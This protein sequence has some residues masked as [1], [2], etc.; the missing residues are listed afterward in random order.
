MYPGESSTFFSRNKLNF[1]I[2][3][4]HIKYKST[5]MTTVMKCVDIV[6]ILIHEEFTDVLFQVFY[7]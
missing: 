5:L 1:M 7:I 2:Q 6:R 4:K 3:S